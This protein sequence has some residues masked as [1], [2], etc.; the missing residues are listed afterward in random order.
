MTPEKPPDSKPEEPP[1]SKE[2]WWSRLIGAL[3]GS[4]QLDLRKKKK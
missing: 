3:V 1:P 4:A 2:P